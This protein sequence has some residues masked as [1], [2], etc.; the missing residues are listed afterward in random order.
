MKRILPV[1]LLSGSLLAACSVPDEPP[2]P[3]PVQRTELIVLRQSTYSDAALIEEEEGTYI[4]QPQKTSP[5]GIVLSFHHSDYGQRKLLHTV[6]FKT[7]SAAL[8]AFEKRRLSELA[9]ALG[10]E[11]VTLSGYA[12]PR[13]GT[14]YNNRLAA[15]RVANVAKYLER[16]GVAVNRDCVFGET[17]L[18]DSDLCEWRTQ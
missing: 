8:S 3:Q 13:A 7:D 17:R 5:F 14:E 15:R 16:L 6:Y 4:G 9:P 2:E 12:D 10:R 1:V 11:G 18:P